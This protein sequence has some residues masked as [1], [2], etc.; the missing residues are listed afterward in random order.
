MSDAAREARVLG[1]VRELSGPGA[2]RPGRGV[3]LRE[4]GLDS[5]G[6]AELALALERDLGVDLSRTDLGEDDRI[7]DLLRAV[8][9]PA[10]RPSPGALPEGTGR[11]QALADALGGGPV[12]WWFRLAVTGADRLPRRGP[13][14]LAMN[15]ESALDIPVIVVACPR[16]ITFM[17]KKEL[18]KNPPVSW[19]L[20]GLGGFRVD[21]D[22][23][24]LPAVDA[25]LAALH[26]GDVLGMYPEGTRSPGT[27]APFL[28]GAAWIALRT[29]VP[30]VPCSISGSEDARRA[31]RP[32]RVRIRVVFH[33][34]IWVERT[35]DPEE[36][37][38]VAAILTGR[39]RDAVE[40]GLGR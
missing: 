6:F 34:P 5:L 21:R 39:V 40:A 7:E 2:R 33:E 32:G 28:P 31:T 14:V 18:F 38:R 11:L 26:R 13:A 17:A 30:L 8:T 20:R 29:G 19:A 22:R 16:R 23:F 24:D 10:P 1:L 3:R 36:R 4:A 12:R 25:A 9:R 27:L 37:R 15:H 35:D